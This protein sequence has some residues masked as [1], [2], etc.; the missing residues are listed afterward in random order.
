MRSGRWR[1]PN[2]WWAL[3][4]GATLALGVWALNYWSVSANDELS[5]AFGGQCSDAFAPIEH[6]ASFG[7]ILGCENR[8]SIGCQGPMMRGSDGCHRL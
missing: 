3:T 8:D 1:F 7:D 2:G 6:I 4:L 5:F